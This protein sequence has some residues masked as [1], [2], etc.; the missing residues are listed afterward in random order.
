[1]EPLEHSVPNLALVWSVSPFL[2]MITS[3]PL[4]H[5]GL[6][7]DEDGRHKLVPLEPL[8]DSVLGAPQV[9]RDVSGSDVDLR[10]DT[11]SACLPRV[12]LD[13]RGVDVVPLDGRPE[14]TRTPPEAGEAIVV[15]A[16]SDRL[17]S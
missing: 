6:P 16:V 17:G 11:M 13:D 5:S 12:F 8:E 10:V 15:G 3:D 14:A 9:Q 2:Q 1:M 7:R 4:E